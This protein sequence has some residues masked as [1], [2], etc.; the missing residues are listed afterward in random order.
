MPNYAMNQISVQ[1]DPTGTVITREPIDFDEKKSISFKGETFPIF[2]GESMTFGD[3][4][5]DQS[6][7]EGEVMK[8]C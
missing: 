8:L 3:F 2:K 6:P 7:Q 5:R 4:M 1:G